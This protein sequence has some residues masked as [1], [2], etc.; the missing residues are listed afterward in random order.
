MNDESKVLC[1]NGTRTWLQTEC[2]QVDKSTKDNSGN[3]L[4]AGNGPDRHLSYSEW[5]VTN[6]MIPDSSSSQNMVCDQ[7][8]KMN[9]IPSTI[10]ALKYNNN[11]N[12]SRWA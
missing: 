11:I 4:K 9:K 7:F 2:R 6:L 5:I 1:A 3:W 10:A 8:K 12:I